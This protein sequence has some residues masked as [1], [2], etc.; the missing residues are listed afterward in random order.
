M[1]SVAQLVEEATKMTLGQPLEVQTSHQV[2]AVLETK[3]HIWLNGSRLIKFQGLLLNVPE[4]TRKPCNTVNP[5]ILL[6]DT[7]TM[8]LTHQCTK[9]QAELL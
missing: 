6:P 1:A 8:G 2:Q 5:A 3:G 9:T 7:R 4:L